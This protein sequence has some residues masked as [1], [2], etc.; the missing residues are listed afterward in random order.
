VSIGAFMGQFD[1]S[2]AQPV[3]PVLERDFGQRLSAISRV[4]VAYTPTLA[5]FLPIFGRSADLHGRKMLYAM[6]FLRC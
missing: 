2:I 3:L 6:G 4:A 5:V 1:A